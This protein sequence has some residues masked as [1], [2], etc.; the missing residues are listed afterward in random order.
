MITDRVSFGA[1]PINS[2]KIKKYNK[3]TKNF[4]DYPVNFVRLNADCR[5]DLVA[6]D[7][8]AQKWKG[9]TYIQKIATASKWM[10]N[11][12]IEVYALTSQQKNFDKLQAN[13]ILGLAEMRFDEKNPKNM[14]LN[15]LQVRPNAMNVNQLNKTNYKYIGSS[16]L[17]SLKKIYKHI[18][19][20]T[21]GNENVERFYKHNGFIDEYKGSGDFRWSKNPIKRL[22]YRI[23]K[24]GL[25]TGLWLFV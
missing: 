12:Q 6:I 5:N 10:K 4:A 20:S 13:N 24:F 19:L 16:I 11:G 15:H 7:L 22:L 3:S 21:D 14:I 23:T 2:V 8:A 9:A 17:T 18:S 25:E 1:K